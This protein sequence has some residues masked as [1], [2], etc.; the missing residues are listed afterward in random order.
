MHNRVYLCRRFTARGSTSGLPVVPNTGRPQCL[1]DPSLIYVLFESLSADS[2]TCAVQRKKY[3]VSLSLAG[4]AAPSCASSLA[5]ALMLPPG[6]LPL[7]ATSCLL[8][9][10]TITCHLLPCSSTCYY[11]CDD[12]RPPAN[13]CHIQ[14]TPTISR[15]LL[16]PPSTGQPEVRSPWLFV[17]TLIA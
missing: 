12:S 9:L 10:P 7:P 16:P 8:T 3:S 15:H 11:Y 6:Y 13:T 1:P 2:K 14:P 4:T 5:V 17:A